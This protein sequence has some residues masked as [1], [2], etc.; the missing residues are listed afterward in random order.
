MHLT[1]R[2]LKLAGACSQ[3]LERFR[4]LFPNGVDV[5]AAVCASVAKEFDWDWAARN[6]LTSRLW[7]DYEAKRAP[8]RDDYEAKRAPLWDDYKAKRKRA[9]LWDD[10][11]AKRAPQRGDYKAKLAP[12]WGDYEAKR[13]LLQDDYEAK[14]APLFGSLMELV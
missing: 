8:L 6:L 1:Y 5:T 7:D 13:A 9:P 3:Q 14:R 12:L 11:K 2:K 10:Y 4:E